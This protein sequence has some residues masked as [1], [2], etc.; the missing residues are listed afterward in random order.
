[1]LIDRFEDEFAVIEYDGKTYD[2][3]RA[4]LPEKAK[5]GDVLKIL[6]DVAKT[7]K[8]AEEIKQ[9]MDDVWADET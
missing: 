1:M 5:E 9:L 4:L 8:N 6:I 2:V 3:P 7:E